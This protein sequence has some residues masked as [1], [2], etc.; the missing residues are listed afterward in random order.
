MKT[1]DY[2]GLARTLPSRSADDFSSSI[3]VNILTNF[4][5]NVLQQLLVGMCLADNI[6]PEVW[7]VPYKQ[8]HFLLKDKKSDLY[9]KEK[10]AAITFIFFDLN[11]Y[12]ESE[13]VSREHFESVLQDI[14]NF[15]KATK[16]IIVLCTFLPPY[17]KQRGLKTGEEQLWDRI[18]GYNKKLHAIAKKCGNIYLF[19]SSAI[20]QG[21]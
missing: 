20:S 3:S 16:G 7:A 8:Y 11:P 21:L 10:D 18:E 14:K 6:Y 12:L 17:E 15:S 5:D 1:L 2:L 19:D 9:K 13:F 4:T